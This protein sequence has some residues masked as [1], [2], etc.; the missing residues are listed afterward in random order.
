NPETLLATASTADKLHLAD[1]DGDSR[2][3]ILLGNVEIHLAK[4]EGGWETEPDRYY[5]GGL[6]LTTADLNHDGKPDLV[7]WGLSA[8]S[9][10]LLI[11]P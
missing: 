5:T 1:V 9:V 3:D 4:V 7:S 8:D 6:S 11:Q 10:A 2:A